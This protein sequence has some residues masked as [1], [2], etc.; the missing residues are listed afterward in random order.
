MKKVILSSLVAFSLLASCQSDP[1]RLSR[2][3]DDWTNIKY[4]EDSLVHGALLQDIIPVY[5]IVGLVMRIGD[6]LF[7]NPWYFWR[8][9]VWNKT[10]TGYNHE[11]PPEGA[12]TVTGYADEEE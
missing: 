8:Y 2:T 9:D 5:P 6:I 1:S 10:G 12:T 7:V 3:W 11:N 4:T